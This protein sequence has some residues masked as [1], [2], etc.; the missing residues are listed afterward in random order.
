MR[1]EVIS[2]LNS[3]MQPMDTDNN[4]QTNNAMMEA[5]LQEAFET[6]ADKAKRERR[7]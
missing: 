5:V 6:E 4:D 1:D 3:D 7:E 2:G